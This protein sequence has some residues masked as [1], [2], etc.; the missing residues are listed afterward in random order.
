MDSLGPTQILLAPV[1]TSPRRAKYLRG[2]CDALISYSISIIVAQSTLIVKGRGGAGP[3]TRLD[4]ALGT[5]STVGMQRLR[6][7]TLWVAQVCQPRAAVEFS[8]HAVDLAQRGDV[9]VVN[10]LDRFVVVAGTLEKFS[11]RAIGGGC[12]LKSYLLGDPAPADGIAAPKEVEGLDNE[13]VLAAGPCDESCFACE[14]YRAFLC[15]G[16]TLAMT[17]RIG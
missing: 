5:A 14:G 13:W 10:A 17:R 12:T 4:N 7:R 9:E 1:G 15:D 16:C 8:V 6:R 3:K 2:R 11:I